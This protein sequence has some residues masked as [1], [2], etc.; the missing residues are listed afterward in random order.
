MLQPELKKIPKYRDLIMVAGV[1]L[2]YL[3]LSFLAV[4]ASGDV[5]I[6]TLVSNIL[7]TIFG[8]FYYHDYPWKGDK[9]ASWTFLPMVF[10]LVLMLLVWFTNQLTGNLLLELGIEAPQVLD[11]TRY[12]A[13]Y[14]ILAVLIGPV[15][16]ELLF[17]GILYRH[18]KQQWNP[19]AALLVSSVVFALMH[20]NLYQMLPAFLGGLFYGLVY[21][22]GGGLFLAILCHGSMNLLTVVL[23]GIEIPSFLYHPAVVIL[24][25]VVLLTVMIRTMV[26]G[27]SYSRNE[28]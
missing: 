7:M 26:T 10:M 17:R 3:G 13:V 27:S 18:L 5:V 23:A 25:W 21:Q 28:A 8:F 6:G 19:V 14:L 2:L 16:E 22:L 4:W 24:L 12:P 15:M 11:T 1:M 9:S 20:G